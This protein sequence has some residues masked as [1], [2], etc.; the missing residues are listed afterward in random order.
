MKQSLLLLSV[1]ICIYSATAQELT[2]K[3]NAL[4]KLEAAE[5]L[6]LFDNRLIDICIYS[7]TAQEPTPKANAPLKLEVAGGLSLFGNRLSADDHKLKQKNDF[8]FKVGV[9][10]LLNDKYEVGISLLSRYKGRAVVNYVSGVEAIDAIN[11]FSSTSILGT[12]RYLA[13]TQDDFT[14]YCSISA[15]FVVNS[16]KEMHVANGY[17]SEYHKNTRI[18]PAFGIGLGAKYKFKD[19]INLFS[20]WQY[21]QSGKLKT[22]GTINTNRD[23]THKKLKYHLKQN[24]VFLGMEFNL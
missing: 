16:S 4:L 10:K 6:T 11:K 8:V 23:I 7:A 5:G 21:L 22:N 14:P 17:R 19:N 2:P 3:A 24:I 13:Y 20:E 15:G 12:L 9:I 1:I 18:F